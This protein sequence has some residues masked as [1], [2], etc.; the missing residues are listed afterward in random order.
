MSSASTSAAATAMTTSTQVSDDVEWVFGRVVVVVEVDEVAGTVVVGRETGVVRVVGGLV[1]LVVGAVV[2]VVVVGALVVVVGSVDAQVG[3]EG[4]ATRRA[5]LTNRPTRRG[6]R[7]NRPGEVAE[8]RAARPHC[9]DALFMSPHLSEPRRPAAMLTTG[10]PQPL[11]P[12]VPVAK[13]KGGTRRSHPFSQP[14]RVQPW[15]ESE[16]ADTSLN[17]PMCGTGV[18]GTLDAMLDPLGCPPPPFSSDSSGPRR[19]PQVL[20]ARSRW[21]PS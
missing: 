21:R 3:V 7:Q 2:V 18:I 9:L 17:R 10:S 14:P 1:E 11:L 20:R 6:A 12:K 8:K 13:R 4:A 19:E 16:T 5:A 15:A